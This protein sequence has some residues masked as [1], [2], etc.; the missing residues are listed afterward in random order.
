MIAPLSDVRAIEVGRSTAVSMAGS[1]LA[2]LG[3]EVLRLDAPDEDYADRA[4]RTFNRGKAS[5]AVT[6]IDAYATR[7]A[8]GVD[9][10]L[11]DHD[12]SILPR[13]AHQIRCVIPSFPREFASGGYG[14]DPLFPDAYAGLLAA[15][16][17]DY[18]GP[19]FLEVAQ[20]VRGAGALAA[21]AVGCA[22]YR[23]NATGRG[24]DLEVSWLA[25]AVSMQMFNLIGRPDVAPPPAW[26][27]DR[28]GW[29]SALH[30]YET[31]D[32]DWIYVGCPNTEFWAKLCFAIDRADLAV[33][34]RLEEMPYPPDLTAHDDV[35]AILEAVFRTQPAA[36]WI[37]RLEANDCIVGPV[38]DRSQWLEHPQVIANDLRVAVS[39][40][41]LGD[42]IQAGPSLIFDGQQRGIA[43]APASADLDA[44]AVL[45]RW[46]PREFAQ[47]SAA[48][49]PPLA[50]ARIIDLGVFAAGPLAS[51]LLADMGAQVTKVE[52]MQGDSFRRLGLGFAVA[53]RGKRTLGLNLRLPE[54][55]AVM[56]R[57]IA[58]ADA[59]ITNWR[60]MAL[61]DRGLTP[62]DVH[63]IND[64]L[65]HIAV[66]GFGSDG[67]WASKPCIDLGVQAVTGWCA[68]Q[69]GGRHSPAAPGPWP[70]DNWTPHLVGLATVAGL[71]ARQRGG[72]ALSLR[73]SMVACAMT[74]QLDRYLLPEPTAPEAPHGEQ[75]M[76]AGYRLCATKD[77]WLL[78]AARTPA[79]WTTF[80]EWV[81]ASALPPSSAA[82]WEAVSDRMGTLTTAQALGELAAR[83]IPCVP[84]QDRPSFLAD[85]QARSSGMIVDVVHPEYGSVLQPGQL[86][87]FADFK[88]SVA[89][90]YPD[91]DRDADMVLSRLHLGSD[92]IE[93]LRSNGVLR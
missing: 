74:F 36:E 69:G 28:C 58:D 37:A 25:G 91:L 64:G 86:V 2:D 29:S 5:I 18:S 65:V 56:N 87:R 43:P 13:A 60:P 79:D 50:G 17:T 52:P 47:T 34:P 16:R 93:D 42:T 73:T 81:G 26:P 35:K 88:A 75:G 85:D 57:L 54:G 71:I 78:V 49:G 77:G 3:A 92:E 55:V 27:G 80:A 53:N 31:L 1:L 4:Y 24:A 39:D 67:P 11:S 23:R 30:L 40:P 20:G 61:I 83:L 22:V 82:A 6:A 62:A 9:V 89:S 46:S 90:S 84:V 44:D 68:A 32:G 70:F 59:L 41:V 14:D 51:R 12:V 10:L 21:F 7:L 45:Q 72:R 76:D 66:S 19:G 15:T 48:P 63:A 33:E 8:A 38:L